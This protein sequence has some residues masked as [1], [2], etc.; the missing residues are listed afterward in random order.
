MSRDPFAMS[1]AVN[2]VEH[3]NDA[4]GLESLRAHRCHTARW[5]MR[6]PLQPMDEVPRAW[7]SGRILS[8][9][10][11]GEAIGICITDEPSPEFRAINPRR[12]VRDHRRE[13]KWR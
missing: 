12:S 6:P 7:N 5:P 10:R 13:D 3:G 1:K 2:S 9:S 8:V 4:T 11:I